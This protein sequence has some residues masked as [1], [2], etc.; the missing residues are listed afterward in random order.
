MGKRFLFISI[1]EAKRICDKSQYGE[2]TL[3]EKIKLN[4]RL[5]WCKIARAYTK[6]NTALTKTIKSSKIDCLNQIEQ[7]DLKA[8]FERQLKEQKYQ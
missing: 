6:R 1:E 7:Q 8:K 4:I 5:S 2:A 3:W